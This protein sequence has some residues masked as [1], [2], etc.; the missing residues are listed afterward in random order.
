MRLRRPAS[1]LYTLHPTQNHHP[2]SCTKQYEDG[3]HD[4]YK[5]RTIQHALAAGGGGTI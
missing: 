1:T 2:H 3:D 5:G 4:T